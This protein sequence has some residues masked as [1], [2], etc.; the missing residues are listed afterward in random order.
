MS[1]LLPK[2]SSLTIPKEQVER[3]IRGRRILFIAINI[4]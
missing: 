1:V 3:R 2:A 4:Q